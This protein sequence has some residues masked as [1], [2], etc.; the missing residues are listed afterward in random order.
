MWAAEAARQG[1]SELTPEDKWIAGAELV[2]SL[3]D[4]ESAGRYGLT[5]VKAN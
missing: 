4:P 2:D 1:M 3:G 5:Q